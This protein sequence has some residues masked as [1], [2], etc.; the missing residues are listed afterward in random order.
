MGPNDILGTIIVS[1][2]FIGV[3][4]WMRREI[5]KSEKIVRNF[6]SGKN[7]ITMEA[8]PTQFDHLRLGFER[9]QWELVGSAPSASGA[10]LFRFASTVS[11]APDAYNLF[12]E[13]RENKSP[14]ER[15]QCDFP[16]KI[17]AVELRA[18]DDT[19]MP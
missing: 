19:R 1:S 18:V 6:H 8:M 13:W 15:P 2:L 10:M 5:Q 17:K 3:Y 9:N 7:S 12:K 4:F 11:N 16:M 14:E